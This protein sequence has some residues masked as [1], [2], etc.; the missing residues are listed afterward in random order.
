MSARTLRT[1]LEK[2]NLTQ[3]DALAIFND[4]APTQ[5]S[6]SQWK[7]Y[8]AKPDSAR[9]FDCPEWVLQRMELLLTGEQLSAYVPSV[10]HRERI[11][12]VLRRPSKGKSRLVVQEISRGGKCLEEFHAKELNE[13]AKTVANLLRAWA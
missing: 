5:L 4:G 11:R 2:A 1:L 9:A 3:T 6:I 12:I 10:D 13:I 8:L 7:A